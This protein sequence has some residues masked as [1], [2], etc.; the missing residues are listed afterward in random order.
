METFAAHS[1]KIGNFVR[2]GR[3]ALALLFALG[4]GS[5]GLVLFNRRHRQQPTP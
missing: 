4:G 1:V 3:M 2:I 5:V